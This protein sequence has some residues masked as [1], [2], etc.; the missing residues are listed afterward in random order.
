V[1]DAAP[2]RDLDLSDALI[3]R[4]ASTQDALERILETLERIE[5]KLNGTWQEGP[6]S[7]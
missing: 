1:T 6:N 3:A 2:E 4:P 5:A 7:L